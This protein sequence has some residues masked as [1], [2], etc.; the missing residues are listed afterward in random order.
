MQERAEETATEAVAMVPTKGT[1]T[2]TEAP[3]IQEALEIPQGT[4]A[5]EGTIGKIGAVTEKVAETATENQIGHH[6]AE[7]ETIPTAGHTDAET[8]DATTLDLATE[9]KAKSAAK[10]AAS[11]GTIERIVQDATIQTTVD[12]VVV[13]DP[14]DT[15]ETTDL[16]STETT[17][18]AL[19]SQT[20]TRVATDQRTGL[21]AVAREDPMILQDMKDATAMTTADAEV[22]P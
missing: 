9:K 8:I 10:D 2:A 18:E 12:P 5:S 16:A 7:T 17:K 20:A 4:E 19:T 6:T 21:Q 14:I 3:G 1:G 11:I 15:K 22:L 13:S